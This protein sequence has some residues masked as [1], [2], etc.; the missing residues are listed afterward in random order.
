MAERTKDA[1][2][3][4]RQDGGPSFFVSYARPPGAPSQDDASPIGDLVQDLNFEIGQH[5]RRE[6]RAGPGVSDREIPLG[7]DW[8]LYISQ[9]LAEAHV[10]VALVSAPYLDSEWCGKEWWVFSQ[11]AVHARPPLSPK[12][13]AILPVL[14]APLPPSRGN[15]LVQRYQYTN[16]G[17]PGAYAKEGLL[18]LSR[19]AG[20]RDSYHQVVNRIARRV[21]DLLVHTTVEPGRMV[22]LESAPSAFHPRHPDWSGVTFWS[23]QPHA[24]GP[25]QA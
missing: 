6:S 15:A 23:K 19:Q 24:A 25:G 13:S 22:N 16:A 3:D 9:M 14:W 4:Q 20:K 11:R 8:G 17:M 7:D 12:T 18:A 10:L 2:S 21:S 1:A 5:V